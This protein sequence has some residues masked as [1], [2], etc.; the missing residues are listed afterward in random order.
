[1][2]LWL[3]VTRP[4]KLRCVQFPIPSPA[5]STSDLGLAGDQRIQGRTGGRRGV[6][7]LPSLTLQA[8]TPDSES[9]GAI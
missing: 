2:E 3:S 8:C 4:G 9:V 6:F 1:M 5:F 7:C